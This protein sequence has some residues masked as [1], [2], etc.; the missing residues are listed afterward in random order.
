MEFTAELIAGFLQGDIVGDPKATVSELSKIE[1]GHPG[2]L[3]FLS[4]PKYEH[5]IYQTKATIVIVNRSFEP[6]APVSATMIKVDD[7]YSCFA[8][9]LE[10][11]IA[12]KPQKQGI[13]K[14]AAIHE[15]VEMGEEMYVGDYALIE[16]GVK[17]GNRC[18][19]YPQVYLGDGVRLGDDVTLF[20]G[21]KIYEAC[22]IG[23]RVTI[24]AGSIIGADGFGFAPD[25]HGVYHKIPQ[26]GNVRIEDD[27]EI[28]A[29]TCID[30]ATMGSTVIHK[31]VKL[32]NL[33]Q[34]GHNV[35]V[36]ANTVAASQVGVAGSSKVG[37]G[38]MMGG[39][40]GIAGHLTIGDG[41]KIASK[42]GVSNSIAAG[43][44]YM[45]SPAMP[46]IKYHRSF[47]VYR[48]LP[49]LS[50]QVRRM[51]KE[52]EQLKAQLAEQ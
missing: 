13:S 22:E 40:V 7:A 44:V 2:S 17:I 11:Y 49:E 52:L 35:T 21:V 50:A 28:G 5:Y 23:N 30:R 10:L 8:K 33:I 9:L 47:A 37:A 39:Q 20:P 25:E 6:T 16:Q 32:D 31:G 19:I 26:I 1:E 51:E 3:A 18:K 36:G 42:S 38:C 41:V 15:S 46:G 24:H 14:L 4:N 12:N 34:I 45:G 29:N 43:Q 48:N 27:V